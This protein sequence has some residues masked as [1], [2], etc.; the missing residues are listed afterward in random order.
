MES[1]LR[2]SQSLL[3]SKESH[4]TQPFSIGKV[5]P[6]SHLRC[7]VRIT[8]EFC[9]TMYVLFQLCVITFPEKF[10]RVIGNDAKNYHFDLVMC[11]IHLAFTLKSG[12]K[13]LRVNVINSQRLNLTW[14]FKH[15]GKKYN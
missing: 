15:H 1:A 14:Y 6:P 7:G 8:R 13:Y 11:S 4:V 2:A 10:Q 3:L 12:P 5:L 9:Q